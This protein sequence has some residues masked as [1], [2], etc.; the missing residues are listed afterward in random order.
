MNR[1]HNLAFAASML[2]A[3]AA[4]AADFTVTSPDFAGG[5]VQ[6]A[7]FSAGM[8]CIG[9]NLSPAISW[10]NAPEGTKSFV[11]TL[12]D[13]DAPTG[14]GWWHWVAIDIPADVAALDG[15][16]GSDTSKM[17]AGAV[18]IAN[19]AGQRGFGGACPPE[20][21]VHDYTITVKALSVEKLPV[22]PEASPALVGF[23]SNMNTLA[24][25][26]ISAR[27]SR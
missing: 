17:P 25:A 9:R 19:D 11:V 14:S 7:Q 27:G 21:E 20:G 8:G 2:T 18:T 23:V 4:E 12:Y 1:F 22:P 26:T 24:T 13:K 10:A 5:Q 6:Q 3:G 16:A 15:G